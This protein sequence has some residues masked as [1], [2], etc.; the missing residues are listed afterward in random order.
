MRTGNNVQIFG[1]QEGRRWSRLEPFLE[2]L[3]TLII[4][5]SKEE[6][7]GGGDDS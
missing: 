7:T 5:E 4:V 3:I 6:K 2:D 1:L